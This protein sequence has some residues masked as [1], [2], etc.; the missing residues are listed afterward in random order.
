MQAIKKK[1][2]FLTFLYVSFLFTSQSLSLK[3]KIVAYCAI[4]K[5]QKQDLAPQGITSNGSL[6]CLKKVH[7]TEPK[8][9]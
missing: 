7:C 6:S 4:F 9:K 1:V 5:C 2:H 3:F 8:P